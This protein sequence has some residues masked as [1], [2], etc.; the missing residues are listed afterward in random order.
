L[1]GSKPLLTG[2]KPLLTGSK[3]L[4]T[5]SKPSLPKVRLFIT[6][7]STSINQ[8]IPQSKK[9]KIPKGY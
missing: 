9:M 5:G 4:L 3:P 1:I 7:K 2:S 8:N 6:L